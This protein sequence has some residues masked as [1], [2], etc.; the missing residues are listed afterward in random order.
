VRV[1]Y[2]TGQFYFNSDEKRFEFLVEIMQR[3]AK[4]SVCA[5]C[6]NKRRSQVKGPRAKKIFLKGSGVKSL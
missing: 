4:R 6:V 1:D 5:C 2:T 3:E